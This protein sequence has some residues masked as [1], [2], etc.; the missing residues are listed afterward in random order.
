MGV[1]TTKLDLKIADT[2]KAIRNKDPKIYDDSV[3]FFD[4]DDEDDEPEQREKKLKPYKVADHLRD[5]VL[6]GNEEEP[7]E[8]VV[9]HEDEL[10]ALKRGFL[11]AADEADD[12][13]K[14]KKKKKKKGDDEDDD[15][16][17][18]LVP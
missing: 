11:D 7:E 4:P 15:G 16:G 14:K 8:P 2:L 18:G 3:K 13:P 5:E 12:E 17:F 6:H 9:S 1:L 10:A